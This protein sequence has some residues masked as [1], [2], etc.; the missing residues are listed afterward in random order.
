LDPR[1]ATAHPRRAFWVKELG[2]VPHLCCSR[3][4]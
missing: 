1:E 2:R 3:S 4:W